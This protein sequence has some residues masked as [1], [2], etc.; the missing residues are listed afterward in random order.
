[1]DTAHRH[2]PAKDHRRP[3]VLDYEIGFKRVAPGGKLSCSVYYGDY[4]DLIDRVLV[5]TRIRTGC[6]FRQK[7]TS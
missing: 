7:T 5:D 6:K 2:L 1:V 4:T 3:V